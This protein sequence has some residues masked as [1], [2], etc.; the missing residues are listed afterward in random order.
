MS[1]E[2]AEIKNVC[3]CECLRYKHSSKETETLY[4]SGFMSPITT[5]NLLIPEAQPCLSVVAPAGA[6][7]NI[8]LKVPGVVH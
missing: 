8:I 1:N 7:L 6:C 3:A 4:F 5:S 2:I